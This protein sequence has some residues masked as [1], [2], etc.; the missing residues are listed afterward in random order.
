MENKKIIL[1]LTHPEALVL[2]NWIS[3]NDEKDSIP[4]SDPAEQKVLW[5]IEGLLENTLVEV[6][7]EN[8]D[9]IIRQAQKD[10]NEKQ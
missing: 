4:F 9:E 7:A 8:Y 1:E 5:K 2:I 10:V 3:K 6:F